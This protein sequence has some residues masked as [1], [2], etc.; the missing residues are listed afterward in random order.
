MSRLV[1][2]SL[3]A[4]GLVAGCLAYYLMD[5]PGPVASAD[6]NPARVAERPDQPPPPPALP[7]PPP[8]PADGFAFPADRGGPLLARLLT[9]PEPPR[10]VTDPPAGPLP[11]KGVAAVERPE[12]PLSAVV[13]R[14]PAATR[15][16]SGKLAPRPPAESFTASELLGPGPPEGVTMP[17]GLP[18]RV[19]S[20]DVSR[21]PAL[22][23]TP[24]PTAD[25]ASLDDPTA[26]FSAQQA[27]AAP[28]P[29]RTS[30]APFV[31][32]NLPDPFE[33][34]SAVRLRTPPA[35]DPATDLPAAL[36]R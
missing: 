8:A 13:A 14:P 36:P 9:P 29:G 32:I 35:D 2:L 4:A 1:K 21:P 16:P 34:A 12:P 18:P 25:R 33:H 23:L 22:P 6:P 24:R 17:A 3:L 31:R 30:P 11:R 20:I 7:A 19:A 5:R 28:P 26:E 15:R 10:S 27:V